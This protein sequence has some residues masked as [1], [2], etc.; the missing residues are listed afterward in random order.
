MDD[1]MT[2]LSSKNKKDKIYFDSSLVYDLSI[3]NNRNVS[4]YENPRFKYE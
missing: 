2:L 3:L 4:P 1:S